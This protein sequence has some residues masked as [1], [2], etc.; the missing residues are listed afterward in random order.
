MKNLEKMLS[1]FQKRWKVAIG[2]TIFVIIPLLL[3]GYVWRQ[4]DI[5]RSD[6]IQAIA[7]IAFVF[8]TGYYA[9]QTQR[10]VKE[11]K[12]ALEEERKRRNAEFGIQRIQGFLSPL[13][14]ML[15]GLKDRLS[16]VTEANKSTLADK[17][18]NYLGLFQAGVVEIDEFI[19][20]NLFMADPILRY[21]LL[22]L[23]KM[24]MP[25]SIDQEAECHVVPW[26]EETEERIGE[27][28]QYINNEISRICQH[29]RKTYGFFSLDTEGR[30][31][32]DDLAVLSER[33]TKRR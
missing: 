1:W 7:I 33:P 5:E 17:F 8:I 21:G 22:G 30:E 31:S 13:L 28:T 20:K 26:K 14:H 6:K 19:F 11:Q 4:E 27:L 16:L 15:E 3:A 10:L 24:N 12:N 2:L 29:I 23:T 9:A 32:M 25:R 18:Q